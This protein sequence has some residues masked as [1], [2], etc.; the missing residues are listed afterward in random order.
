VRTRQRGGRSAAVLG[1]VA[2]VALVAAAAPLA[3]APAQALDHVTF[4]TNW[5]AE[6]EHGGFYQA[7]ATGIY[8]RHGLDVTL[9]MG[10][11]QANN[12]QL[13]AAGQIDFNVGAD[14]FAALNYVRAGVPV[15]TVAAI[16]QK[17]PQVL[18]AHPGQGNDSF[19]ALK[20]KPIMLASAARATFWNFLKIRFGYTDDQIRTYTFN[21]APF[22]ADVKAIQEGYLTSEPYT[23]AKAGVKPVVLLMA[24]HG[25]DSY[26]TTLECSRRLVETRP[27]LV[28]RFVDASVE[29]WYSYLYSDPSPANRL[30]KRDNPEMTDGLIAYGI[31]ALKS[32]GVVDSGDAL[33]GGI[34]AMT[35]ARWHSFAATMIRAGLYPPA[36][37]LSRAYTLRFVNRRVGLPLKAA[38][39]PHGAPGQPR[40]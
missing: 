36:L 22:L 1:A 8:R 24:D 12:S 20:G 13:L 34:G 26:S 9:R 19:A 28:Q 27:D 5:K 14:S 35:D 15:V 40:R 11:P 2:G 6:A 3:A 17:D 16:F 21:M 25:F 29:G 7:L 4:A 23:L 10:G 37:D 18:L 30:I 33:A 31:A 39:A 38:S 32:H